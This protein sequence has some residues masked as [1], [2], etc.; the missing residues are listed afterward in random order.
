[1][2]KEQPR[3]TKCPFCDNM[4]QIQSHYESAL[5]GED[6]YICLVCYARTIN[7]WFLKGYPHR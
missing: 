6:V 4:T 3:Y 1:M 5:D 7:K 2:K